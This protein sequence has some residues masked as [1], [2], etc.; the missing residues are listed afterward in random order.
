MFVCFLIQMKSL[1]L[2]ALTVLWLRLHRTVWILILLWIYVLLLFYKPWLLWLLILLLQLVAYSLLTSSYLCFLYNK[3]YDAMTQKLS[4]S[5][6]SSKCFSLH[7]I[8]SSLSNV[9]LY[10]YQTYLYII[11]H[12][13][14]RLFD[15]F[16]HLIVCF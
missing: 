2:S 1:F 13:I 16:F 7:Y 6:P 9:F 10:L 12:F 4:W 15:F 11:W 8:I 14:L 5:N 3:R